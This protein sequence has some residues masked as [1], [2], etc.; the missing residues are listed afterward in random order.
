MR[1]DAVLFDLDGVLIDSA[2]VWF[3][4]LNAAAASLRYPAIARSVFD[5]RF[6]Q[7]IEADRE[8]FFPRH[9][10]SEL[11]AYFSAHF[12]DH[13]EHL[14]VAAGLPALFATLR[15]RR[16]QSAVVTN[17]A[18]PLARALVERAGATPDTVVGANDAARPKPAPDLVL[19]A[20]RR[21]RVEP[22]RAVLVGDSAYDRDAAR[23]AGSPFVGLRIDGD[24]RIGDLVELLP[25]LNA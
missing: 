4:V 17:S 15:A 19:E 16:I 24:H 13:V 8:A 22:E 21:L 25:L 20:C 9:G 18:T 10:T 12:L 7:G 23:A 11:E 3:R 6:G 5:A 14:R 2:E 1:W